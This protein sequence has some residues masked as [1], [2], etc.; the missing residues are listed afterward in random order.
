VGSENSILGREVFILQQEFLIDQAGDV[1]QQASPFV[2]W[3][4]EHHHN[5]KPSGNNLTTRVP[6][7]EPLR[8]IGKD[9]G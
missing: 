2:V 9:V 5:L 1:R 7:W 8:G 4:E 3:H 6:V